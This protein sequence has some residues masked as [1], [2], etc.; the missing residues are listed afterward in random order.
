[1][2][3][4]LRQ[5]VQLSQGR[6]LWVALALT[7]IAVTNFAGV[8]YGNAPGFD[9]WVHTYRAC[10]THA[11]EIVGRPLALSSMLLMCPIFKSDPTNYYLALLASRAVT[12]FLVY[13]LIWQ[14]APQQ[15]LFA[16][17]G[18]LASVT[19]MVRND[20]FAQSFIQQVDNF[21]SLVLTL[22]ALN[23]FIAHQHQNTPGRK[24]NWLLLLSLGLITVTPLVRESAIPLLLVVPVGVF[25][26]E[27]TWSRTRLIG[28]GLWLIILGL[29][30][31]RVVAVLRTPGGYQNG[32]FVSL[33]PVRLYWATI[34]QF[35]TV[36]QPILQVGPDNLN[37]FR[38]P[39][40]LALLV[41]SLCF[42]LA[43]TWFAESDLRE[44]VWRHIA[45]YGLWMVA[46]LGWAWVG[47]SAY[48]PA[49]F[50]TQTHIHF[51]SIAGEGVVLVAGLWLV[52]GLI[53]W[54]PVRV[55]VQLAGL[56]W[57]TTYGVGL[58]NVL[59]QDLYTYG[60]TWENQ[61][62]FFR[63]LAQAV[64]ALK[65]P[66]LFV[67]IKNPAIQES[68]FISQ[69]SVQYGAR[70]FYND[71]ATTF[72]SVGNDPSAWPMTDAGILM[73]ED[74]VAEPHL[75]NWN[76]MIFFTRDLSGKVVMLD[77]LP[78]LFSNAYRQNLYRPHDLILASFIPSRIEGTFPLLTAVDW[79][80]DFVLAR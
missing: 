56:A 31:L 17:A 21:L 63:S 70:Y 15:P 27:R 47:F 54:R 23:F 24:R 68:G 67:Y 36:F 38:L 2:T 64:P 25:L 11:T 76:Q 32:A 41:T 35:I 58:T 1:M 30:A 53:R 80:T 60:A 10:Q 79:R 39:I 45:R 62:Y 33:D 61:A 57:L 29:D 48:L 75:F 43:Q 66:T 3:T 14:M 28:L 20:L 16:F 9:D 74:W 42:L 72:L 34:N 12:A 77:T 37:L 55:G 5:P 46:G 13:L 65:G 18:G 50:A 49:R 8:D 51:L 73:Q 59:Q 4:V 26:L 7:I 69:G 78:P 40:A 52:S 44:P 19:F 22:L 6:H 71:Q